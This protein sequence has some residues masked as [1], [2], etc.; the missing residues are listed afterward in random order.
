MKVRCTEILSFEVLMMS[1]LGCCAVLASK[2][3]TNIFG[4]ML[5]PSSG[6]D[7]CNCLITAALLVYST[8]TSAVEMDI[9]V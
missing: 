3:F 7:L 5:P 6:R 1:L 9:I 2:S 8:A 4:C